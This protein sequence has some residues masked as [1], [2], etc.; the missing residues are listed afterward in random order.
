[1]DKS[2]EFSKLIIDQLIDDLI[3]IKT[4]ESS[5]EIIWKLEV[6]ESQKAFTKS[7]EIIR[8]HLNQKS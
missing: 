8:K 5:I 1:M 4:L 6:L 2:L 3:E 7:S